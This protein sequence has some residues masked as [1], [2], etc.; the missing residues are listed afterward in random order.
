MSCRQTWNVYHFYSLSVHDHLC[1]TLKKNEK[2]C[3]DEIIII[4]AFAQLST[5]IVRGV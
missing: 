4:R 5:N 2:E 1:G 3:K